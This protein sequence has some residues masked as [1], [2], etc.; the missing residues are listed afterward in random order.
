M[1]S[2]SDEKLRPF[3]CFSVK[4][5]GGSPTEPDLEYR[6]GDQD[7]GNPDKPV[8]SGLQVS[9]D[10]GENKTQLVTS[11]RRFTFKIYNNPLRKFSHFP[12]L[13]IL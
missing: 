2:A 11:P 10:S 3:N 13:H 1:T 6:V 12:V 5:T 8:S 9:G 4:G 7:I